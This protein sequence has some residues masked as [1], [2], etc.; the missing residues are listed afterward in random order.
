MDSSKRVALVIGASRGMGRQV[1][2][3]L[4]TA[5]YRA[6]EIQE[7]GGDA[8]AIAA[9][10]RDPDA[11][12]KMVDQAVASFGRLDVLIYNSGA[13]W[14]ASVE[15][16]PVKRFKLM[17]QVNVEGLYSTIQAALPHFRNQGWRGRIVVVSPPIYS[18]FFRGKTAYA[19]GKVAMSVLT[20]GLAM[21]FAREGKNNMAIS[22]IW[23]ATA[24]QSAATVGKEDVLSDLRK[25]TLGRALLRGNIDICRDT[26]HFDLAFSYFPKLS[27]MGAP[28]NARFSAWLTSTTGNTCPNSATNPYILG[29]R[30]FH[31]R[32][33]CS[34]DQFGGD[35]RNEGNHADIRECISICDGE[36]QCVGVTWE[37]A[38]GNRADGGRC[39]FKSVNVQQTSKSTVDVAVCEDCPGIKC[40]GD[41]GKY[42]T[43]YGKQF[44]LAC[45]REPYGDNVDDG[46]T[47][48]IYNTDING[49][50]NSCG[51]N[52]ACFSASLSGNRKCLLR[53]HESFY[54]FIRSTDYNHYFQ[55]FINLKLFLHRHHRF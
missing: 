55:R 14:W 48:T 50:L 11:V 23:V 13:I 49:C 21:D 25:P 35:Y 31:Y 22:S 36:E 2:I 32:L 42:A 40:P 7:A 5:G 39:Y 51:A 54:L 37:F 33:K 15:N 26:K 6:R 53:G 18:R 34:T 44:K 41:E 3:D 12:K 17:Q 52:P 38:T 1:A 19:M 4:A 46:S 30:G 10:T 43:S 8:L 47:N 45:G 24:I 20:K 28:N 29:P 27:R 9:D 16:T